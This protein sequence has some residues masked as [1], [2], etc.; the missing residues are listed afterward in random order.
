MGQAAGT[1]LGE[2]LFPRPL[3]VCATLTVEGYYLADIRSNTV[4]VVRYWGGG[5]WSALRSYPTYQVTGESSAKNK[6][7]SAWPHPP[8]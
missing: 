3:P 1:L 8:Q 7:S 6:S 5:A 2:L 4:S